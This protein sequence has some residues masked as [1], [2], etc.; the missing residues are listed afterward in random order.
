MAISNMG[1]KPDTCIIGLSEIRKRKRYLEIDKG[2]FQ[3][4]VLLILNIFQFVILPCIIYFPPVNWR[5]I[6]GI[7][8]KIKGA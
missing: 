6:M 2:R 1:N 4:I 8:D 7:L 3:L 5:G